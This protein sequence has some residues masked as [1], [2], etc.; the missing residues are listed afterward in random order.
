MLAF[1]RIRAVAITIHL[2]VASTAYAGTTLNIDKQTGD[3]HRVTFDDGAES[4]LLSVTSRSAVSDRPAVSTRRIARD[5]SG[6][7]FGQD[8]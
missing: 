6:W 2:V 5:G 7:T 4:N 8:G 1:N 3:W